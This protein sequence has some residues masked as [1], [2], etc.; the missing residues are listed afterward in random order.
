MPANGGDPVRDRG[1]IA[2]VLVCLEVDGD[3]LGSATDV[4][5][6]VTAGA[7]AHDELIDCRLD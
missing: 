2:W 3:A 5:F 1:E 7:D 4:D 6:A